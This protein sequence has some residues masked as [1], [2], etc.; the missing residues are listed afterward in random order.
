MRWR[1]A[2]TGDNV[3][4]NMRASQDISTALLGIRIARISTVPFFVISQ[5]KTQI[6]AL[7]AHGAAVTVVSSDGAEV[8]SQG[9]FC[10]AGW[11][12]IE[13]PRALSPFKDLY[14]IWQLFIFFRR[15]RIQVAHSTTPKAGLLTAV[16]AALAGVPVRLHTF[17]G[18][19]W[20]SMHGLRRWL[21]RSCDR[22]IQALS[23]VCYTD[24]ESQRAFLINQGH[25][26]PDKLKVIGS[27]SLAGVDLARFSRT[28]FPQVRRNEIRAGLG[29]PL[30]AV[31][32]L[33]VGR[34]TAEKG[35]HELMRAFAKLKNG[36]NMAGASQAC[37]EAH[38]VIVGPFDDD[39]GVPGHISLKEILQQPDT[40]L[41]GYT[42]CPEDYMA[43]SDV[44]CL[45][46]YREGF[47][48]VV[49]EAAAMGLP[50]VG[51]DIYGLSDAVANG[52]TGLLVPSHDSDTLEAALRVLLLDDSLRSR[53][54][55][56]ALERAQALFA[57]DHVNKL[58]VH[59][60]ASLLHQAH[61][62]IGGVQQ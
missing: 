51:T 36:G 35:V 3:A 58:Q 61:I 8:S 41:V 48:T 5:L 46:S 25:L 62:A 27:G 4:T 34:I 32:I 45:P 44:L 28:H 37:K 33:F 11:Q 7:V 26:V 30:H 15:S 40:H 20:V 60:Y 17:T 47:G 59:E 53:M 9:N 56:A 6:A 24:S 13:I 14:A 50:T 43:I 22:L 42:R 10:N 18:Q 57:S 31:V 2:N 38:L 39:S 52:V 19:P 21:V 49:I 12:V 16:A 54:G 29:I 23:T 1:I 55:S